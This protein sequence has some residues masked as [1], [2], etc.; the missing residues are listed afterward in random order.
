MSVFQDEAHASIKHKDGK[1]WEYPRNRE[2]YCFLLFNLGSY[3]WLFA[4][5]WT[6]AHQASLSFTISWSL[7]ILMSIESVMPSNHLNLHHPLLLLP[8]VLSDSLQ[9]HGLQHARLPWPSPTPG[10]CSNSCPLNRWC[11]PT[12]S[13]SVVPFPSAFNLS[14]HQGLLKWVSSLH[15]IQG[16]I[17]R[18][19]SF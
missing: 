18:E 2:N 13:S 4:T 3:V 1:K 14:Q 12:I 17:G 19:E 10:A 8:S 7:L 15:Q 6:V 11:H 16:M 5:P 9:P